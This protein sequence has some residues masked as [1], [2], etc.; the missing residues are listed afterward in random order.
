[1]EPMLSAD[2]FENV[3]ARVRKGFGLRSALELEGKSLDHDMQDW[4][5]EDPERE[6]SY[7]SAK[8]EAEDNK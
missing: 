6:E 1:M 7:L 5:L 4:F 2:E 8:K 3:L